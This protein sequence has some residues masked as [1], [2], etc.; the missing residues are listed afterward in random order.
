MQNGSRAAMF[1]GS[2]GPSVLD[3]DCRCPALAGLQILDTGSFHARSVVQQYHV[4]YLHRYGF[5]Y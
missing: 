5:I 4:F 1:P 3:Y 2:P